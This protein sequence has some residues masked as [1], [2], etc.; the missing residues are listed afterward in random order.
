MAKISK[1]TLSK[2]FY[3][4]EKSY[5]AGIDLHTALQRESEQ[6]SPTY[7]NIMQSIASRVCRGDSF[8]D[9]ISALSDD[10]PPLVQ[11]VVKAG[12]QGGRLEES[13]RRLSQHY[14]SLV[15]FR[16]NLLAR[17]AWPMFEL[18]M[19][20]VVV[21]VMILILG[22]ILESAD[23]PAIDWFG[24]GL[25]VF[26]NFALY[27]FIVLTL[28]SAAALL[29]FGSMWGWFGELPMKIARRIPLIGKTIEC[30]ALSRFAWTMS[31]A[32][33]AGM[34][35]QETTKL[36]L[37]ATQNFYFTNQIEPIRNSLDQGRSIHDSLAS[38]S[39]FP[40]DFL[41]YVDNGEIAGELAET[42]DRV[43][44]DLQEQAE[45]NLKTITTIGF[46]ITFLFTAVVVGAAVI[47]L[48]QKV[49]IEQIQSF[50]RF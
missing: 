17:M 40:R 31:V 20:V 30:L 15:Q 6:G 32:E 46:V 8:S 11:A 48:F 41:M 1:A 39:V 24:F 47:L 49:Y 34:R 37:E 35:P 29:I 16:R 9:S 19:A 44:K 28:L 2:L 38:T 4:L 12:E 13:F 10:F 23:I 3:R 50:S 27:C 22:F 36:A 43:S 18:A 14:N 5:T 7:R 42:L 45:N 33:N 25:S 26:G 21:G